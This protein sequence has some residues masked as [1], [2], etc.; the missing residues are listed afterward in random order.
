MDLNVSISS[1]WL[2]SERDTMNNDKY[3]RKTDPSEI[4]GT[5]TI[6]KQQTRFYGVC[7]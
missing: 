7:S 4:E 5:Y 2:L 3:S 1:V 6:R